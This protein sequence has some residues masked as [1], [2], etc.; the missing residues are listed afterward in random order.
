M[1]GNPIQNIVGALTC[2]NIITVIDLPVGSLVDALTVMY[3]GTAPGHWLG[4]KFYR[5]LGAFIYFPLGIYMQYGESSGTQIIVLAIA[6]PG[7]SPVSMLILYFGIFLGLTYE[8][9]LGKLLGNFKAFCWLHIWVH[10]LVNFWY[11]H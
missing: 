6:S 11:L 10:A 5:S 1:L 9:H 7:T 3:L 8:T 4:I 2:G